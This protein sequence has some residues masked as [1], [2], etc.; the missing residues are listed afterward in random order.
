MRRLRVGASQ[1]LGLCSDWPSKA[2]SRQ[3]LFAEPP[4][5]EVEVRPVDARRLS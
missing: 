5:T 4:E 3:G 2:L 1:A